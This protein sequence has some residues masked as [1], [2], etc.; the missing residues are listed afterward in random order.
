MK[1]NIRLKREYLFKKSLEAKNTVEADKK[2]RLD[3]AITNNSNIP[4]DLKDE[5]SKLR[6]SA[7]WD[8]SE[9]AKPKTHIDDEYGSW[10]GDPRVCVTTSRD[11]S[12]KLKEFSKELRLLFPNSRRMNRGQTT[13]PEL[14][15][16]CRKADFTDIVVCTEH[17]GD[18]DG[19][20]I[21]HLPYGPTMRIS[22]SDC[23]TRHDIGKD[24]AE[25]A[26]EASPHLVFH[27][28][29]SKLGKRVKDILAHLFPVAK[30]DSKRIVTFFN[31]DDVISFRHHVVKKQRGNEKPE[32]VEI[33]PRFEMRPYEIRLG[34]LEQKDGAEIEWALR[35]Y[36]NSA[37][38]KRLFGAEP[39]GDI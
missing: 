22:L 11:P 7:L 17:R 14:V 9:T 21:C 13:L 28:M 29:E 39:S 31:R 1:R 34:T 15:D 38:K 4:E 16:A 3:R 10:K 5:E 20:V 6:A 25:N 23:V 33:G 2:A 24:A 32:L 19:L 8:D 27:D 12:S 18:A 26:S 36:T 30:A 35:S 37:R